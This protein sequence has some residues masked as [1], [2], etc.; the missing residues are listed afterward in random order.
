MAGKKNLS[1]STIEVNSQSS[2][3]EVVLAD[4]LSQTESI[5]NMGSSLLAS[6]EKLRGRENYATWNL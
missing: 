4:T 3:T 6:I 2:Q 5:V 1:E